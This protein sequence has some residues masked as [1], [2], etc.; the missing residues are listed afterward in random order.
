MKKNR[1]GNL[2]PVKKYNKM[3]FVSTII[4]ILTGLAVLIFGI[5]YR[6][7]FEIIFG[8]V[9]IIYA[10]LSFRIRFSSLKVI[11]NK[12]NNKLLFLTIALIIF[13]LVNPIGN[14]AV[15][16]DLYKRDYVLTGGFDEKD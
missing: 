15:I 4:W 7:I 1:R 11:Y 14:I 6:E 2:N 13:S 12:E 16:F 3:K 5:H 10:L 9:S 8:S